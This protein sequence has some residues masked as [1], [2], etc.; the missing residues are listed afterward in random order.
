MI[1]TIIIILASV[2]IALFLGILIIL[3][4]TLLPKEKKKPEKIQRLLE[5][6]P[7]K[8]CGAC[9]YAGCEEYVK[10]IAENPKIA[11]KDKCPF[12]LKDEQKL[13]ELEE[14]LG[15]KIEKKKKK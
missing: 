10:T 13:A 9:G 2:A 12:M 8:D 4:H 3:V 1:D 7:K 6:V 15:V 5:I 14:I 11:Q